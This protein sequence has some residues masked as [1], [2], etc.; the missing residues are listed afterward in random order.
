MKKHIVSGILSAAMAF[1]AATGLVAPAAASAQARQVEYLTRALTAIKVNGGVYLSWR[2]FGTEPLTQKYDIYRDGIKIVSALDATNYTDNGGF[3]YNTYQVVPSATAADKVDLMCSKTAV[4][5][6]DYID[7]PLD[8]PSGGVTD[9][10]ES[11]T[12]SAN[13]ISVIDVDGDGEYEYIVKWNPSNAKDNSNHGQTGNVLIDCCKQD[14]T[15]LWRI[16]LG[17]N[18]RAGAHYTQ[19]IAYDFDGDGKGEVAMRTAPG[20][21]DSTGQYVSR[22]SADLNN[23]K[24][25]WA[26]S[27]TGTVYNDTSDLRQTGSKSGHII[28]GPDWLTMFNGET[29]VAMQTVNFPIQRGS[30]SSWGDSYGNRSERYLAGV[31][32]LDGVKPSLIMCRG[33][34]AKAGMGAYDWDGTKFTKLWSRVDS[35]DKNTLYTNGNHQLSIA[36][37]DNDG[38][39]EIIWGS[40]IVDDNGSMLNAT[41]HGHG[42]AMHVSD[43]NNDGDQEVF[44]VHEEKTYFK[45]WGAEL[46]NAGTNTIL[47]ATPANSDNGRGV[48]ANID[49]DYAYQNGFKSYFWSAADGN[50]YKDTG[51]IVSTT[52]TIDNKVT[53]INAYKPGSC[54]SLIYWDGDLSRELLDRNRI[55]KYSVENGTSR[56]K[57]FSNVHTNNSTKENASISADLFGDWREEVVFPTSDDSALRVFITV[58][59]TQYKLTTLMHDTQ[60]RCAIAWQNV[61]Y[62]QPPHPSY[63]IGKAALASGKNY[64]APQTGFD[65]VTYAAVPQAAVAIPDE[66]VI[67]IASS[68]SFDNGNWGIGTSATSAAPYNNIV[69]TS[70]GTTTKTFDPAMW[71]VGVK[72]ASVEEFRIKADTVEAIIN[73]GLSGAINARLYTAVYSEDGALFKASI[74]NITAAAGGVTSEVVQIGSV[75]DGG[76]VKAF[77]WDEENKPYTEPLTA[78]NPGI[79]NRVIKETDGKAETIKFAFDWMPDTNNTIAIRTEGGQNLVSVSKQSGYAVKYATGTNT[80]Q[81]VHST[82]TA[83]NAWY[84][85]EITMDMTAKT[86]DISVLDYTT[87]GATVKTVYSASF[88]GVDGMPHSMTV[89]GKASLDNINI[90]AVNYNVERNLVNFS[91]KDSGGN[92]VSAAKISVGGVTLT[93]DENGAAAIKLK[94][95]DYGYTITKAEYKTAKSPITVDGTLRIDEILVNG[96]QRNIYVKYMYDGTID[97]SDAAPGG[98]IGTAKENSI[99]TL[100]DSAKIDINNYTF[101]SNTEDIVPG[102]E[103]LAGHTYNLEFDSDKSD[104]TDVTIGEDSDTVIVLSYKIK[105]APGSADTQL[106]NIQYGE[107]GIGSD[108]AAWSVTSNAYE[109]MYDSGKYIRIA[110]FGPTTLTVNIPNKSKDIVMEFDIKYE[111]MAWGGNY[112]GITPYYNTTAGQGFGMRTSQ[113]SNGQWQLAYRTSNDQYLTR[114]SSDKAY[115]YA[116]NWRNKWMHM[117]VV[118]DGTQLKVT[119][120]N[121]DTGVVYIQDGIIPLKSSVGT[122][123]RP[124][125]KVVFGRTY[126]SGNAVVGFKNFKAYSVGGASEYFETTKQV[127]VPSSTVF[128]VKAEHPSDMDGVTYDASAFYGDISY[129]LR[130]MNNNVTAPNGLSLDEN[131]IL[132]ASSTFDTSTQYKVVVLLDGCDWFGYDLMYLEKTLTTGLFKGFGSAGDLGNFSLTQKSGYSLSNTN[133]GCVKYS[134]A[135]NTACANTVYLKSPIIKTALDDEFYFAIDMMVASAGVKGY[136]YLRNG[137]GAEYA[138]AET[139]LYEPRIKFFTDSSGSTDKFNSSNGFEFGRWYTFVYH[140]TSMSASSRNI[141]LDIYDQLTFKNGVREYSSI[142]KEPLKTVNIT[143]GAVDTGSGLYFEWQVAQNIGSGSVS[144]ADEWY[145][146]NI[147]YQYYAFN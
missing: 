10:G 74:K 14:G 103:E 82:L 144:T 106:L 23:D 57:T 96:E 70:T 49:D 147:C 105:R 11:Y 39:D 119:Q 71:T 108:G 85:T 62:N 78:E 102:Y 61:G 93:T 139:H 17:I 28:K 45:T 86:A 120:A 24:F 60:Y 27:Y 80:A 33:Y 44:T 117:I 136:L 116:Y 54:N 113:E 77:L 16:D 83:A 88:A 26:D 114:V 35:S 125:N 111:D 12:Y 2:L 122:S 142:G 67:L 141:R 95:G 34:Y 8:K 99:Y 48:M 91:V 124:I 133:G 104:V 69:T 1:S 129:E 4:L 100:P 22:V 68:E 5:Q 134:R 123:A 87:A 3:S 135:A 92:A 98:V 140:G 46:R 6:N 41:G 20:S 66:E 29:G 51:E 63:Y 76:Y 143:P 25:T 137:A 131:G 65:F 42:D 47:A 56:L 130:D 79:E 112:F 109:R 36:D 64:L 9:A 115:S 97:I 138:K 84:H 90:G 37:A 73:N 15:R 118:C 43:F 40:A 32:Y 55:D 38:K 145:F 19:F 81:S 128:T 127:E 89:T 121:K 13:D 58:E 21:K 132:T 110:N 31:A 75:P 94:N 52:Q 107:G 126:G 30:V 101:T 18:I 7:I 146:D 72:T 59:P 50:L 53:T